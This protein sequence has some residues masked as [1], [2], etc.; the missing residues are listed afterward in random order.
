MN[1]QKLAD[2]FHAP[3]CIISVEKKPDGDMVKF[4]LLPA[5]SSILTP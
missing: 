2:T 5:I 1:F 3:A 4:V